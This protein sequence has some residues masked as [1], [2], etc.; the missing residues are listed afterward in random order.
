MGWRVWFSL[1]AWRYF[2]K[3]GLIRQSFWGFFP[4][5]GFPH[6]LFSLW[7]VRNVNCLSD[8]RSEIQVWAVAPV[9]RN[10]LH[11]VNWWRY[12][13]V[14]D[15]WVTPS[16]KTYYCTTGPAGNQPPTANISTGF[17]LLMLMILVSTP[18][19][20]D[21]YLTSCFLKFRSFSNS[22]NAVVSNW[23]THFASW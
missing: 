6:L 13:T 20:F 5:L 4:F 23:I 8:S 15:G 9:R 21:C 12:C 11:H 22:L 18:C 17:N 1:R 14:H 3:T 10:Q 7:Q 2:L 19:V 16:Y